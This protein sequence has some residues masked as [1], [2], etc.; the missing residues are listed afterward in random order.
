[1]Q[2]NR[3]LAVDALPCRYRLYALLDRTLI[4]F[5][6]IA[7]HGYHP[8]IIL[9][10]ILNR[11]AFKTFLNSDAIYRCMTEEGFYIYLPLNDQ[12]S[13]SMIFERNYAP[14]ISGLIR[15]SASEFDVYIDVG[16]NLGY[17]CL[18]ACTKNKDLRVV[19]I[20]PNDE[21]CDLISQ[22]MKY[23]GYENYMILQKALGQTK[24]DVMLLTAKGQSSTSRTTYIGNA[25]GGLSHF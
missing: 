9:R 23:N 5:G 24:Q 17:F 22:S 25:K 18:L 20:E 8:F 6:D 2:D 4:K 21:L 14:L 3:V 10:N 15:D 11:I 13:A 19:A 12:A 16:A 1:M 7:I